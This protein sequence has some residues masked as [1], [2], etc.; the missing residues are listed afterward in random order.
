MSKILAIIDADVLIYISALS[1]W[2]QREVF[3]F[4]AREYNIE[5]IWVPI[6]VIE[7]IGMKIF[8]R[9]KKNAEPILL[10]FKCPLRDN[11]L[12]LK[13]KHDCQ[14][15][16]GESDGIM[17][18]IKVLGMNSTAKRRYK[19]SFLVPKFISNDGKALSCQHVSNYVIPWKLLS[20]E[21]LVLRGINVLS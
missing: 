21:L 9:L 3:D 11:Y 2:E 14:I 19:I 13:V 18:A 17:Q 8:E 20:N 16:K 5:K 7:E 4:F 6:S 10:I 1:D 12:L 15:D